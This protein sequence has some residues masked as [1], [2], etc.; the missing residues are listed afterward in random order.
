MECQQ[1]SLDRHSALPQVWEASCQADV[2][3]QHEPAVTG[4][5]LNRCLFCQRR[6]ASIAACCEPR[7]RTGSPLQAQVWDMPH[8]FQGYQLQPPLC[9]CQMTVMQAVHPASTPLPGL[10]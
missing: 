6:T 10:V 3:Q 4:V 8:P 9:A 2:Q 1:A 7:L 5:K